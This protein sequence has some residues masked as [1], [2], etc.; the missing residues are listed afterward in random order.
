MAFR[1]KELRSQKALPQEVSSY[2]HL[3]VGE[4]VFAVSLYHRLQ[5]KFGK[6]TSHNPATETAHSQRADPFWPHHAEG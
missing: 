4:D 1:L 3:V 5:A 2:S 6:K